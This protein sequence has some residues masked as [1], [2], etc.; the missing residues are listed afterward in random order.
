MQHG[1]RAHNL[2]LVAGEEPGEITIRRS[3]QRRDVDPKAQRPGGGTRREQRRGVEASGCSS[4]TPRKA[5]FNDIEGELFR[6]LEARGEIP[7][8]GNGT[9]VG[10]EDER[11]SVG[12]Q[13]T[14]ITL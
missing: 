1:N 11:A 5:A 13:L 10:H 14:V 6:L 3:R 7:A 8:T 4:A 12:V 9:G 2:D